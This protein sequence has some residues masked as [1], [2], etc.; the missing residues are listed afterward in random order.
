MVFL[1]KIFQYYMKFKEISSFFSVLYEE[2][3]FLVAFCGWKIVSVVRIKNLNL[4]RVLHE[5]SRKIPQ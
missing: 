3:W 2:L 4:T 5:T 1:V